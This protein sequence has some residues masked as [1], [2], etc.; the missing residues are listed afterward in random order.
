MRIADNMYDLPMS[1]ADTE[2]A[3]RDLVS[4]AFGETEV[5]VSSE[6]VTVPGL[7]PKFK[8][9]LHQVAG[10]KWMADRESGKKTGGILADDMG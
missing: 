8:L 5:E 4:G 2:K 6:D 9:L 10:R 1:P 3:I 7:D